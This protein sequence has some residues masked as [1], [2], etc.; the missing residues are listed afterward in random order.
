M[1]LDR[2]IG[3]Q[4]FHT[5]KAFREGNQPD[6]P[7]NNRNHTRMFHPEGENPGVAGGLA[8]LDLIA[9]M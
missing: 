6:F 4:G 1:G 5:T 2:R 8:A 3:H 9:R 7:Q